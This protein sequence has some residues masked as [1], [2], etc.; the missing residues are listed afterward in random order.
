MSYICQPIE[1]APYNEATLPEVPGTKT[2]DFR[3]RLAT[4]EKDGRRKWIYPKRVSGKWYR[5]RT[6]VSWLLLGIMFSGPFIKI[7]GNP[8]LL[9]NV[10]E[11]K[12]II[13]GQIFWP[14]DFGIFAIAMLVFIVGI[15]I[16]TTAFGRLWCGWACPQTILME[17]VF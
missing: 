9:L 11:R 10:V 3:D 16:F 15:I 8:L 17:M 2:E 12:F 13:L 1:E 5:Y 7:N 4:A 14:Q 6:Y